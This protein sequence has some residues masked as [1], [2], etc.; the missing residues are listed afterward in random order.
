MNRKELKAVDYLHAVKGI[1]QRD[2]LAEKTAAFLS[3]SL[4]NF[5]V[6]KH[7]LKPEPFSVVTDFEFLEKN[8][9]WQK[10]FITFSQPLQTAEAVLFKEKYYIF[11]TH[12]YSRQEGFF[13]I[14]DHRPRV[15]IIDVIKSWQ[16]LDEYLKE[17]LAALVPALEGK[18]ANMVSQ[19][20]HDTEA[21]MQLIPKESMPSDL[22][23]R[24]VYQKKLNANLL[25][26][27]REPELLIEKEQVDELLYAALQFAGLDADTLP[28]TI[29]AE[30]AEIE[31][32]AELFAK[33]LSEI[34]NNALYACKG[35]SQKI[36]I[37]VD[38]LPRKSPLIDFR[39]MRIEIHNQGAIIPRDFLPQ[40]KEPF[41]TT[42]KQDGFSGFGLS[43]A[44]KIF[45]AHHGSMEISS[46]Q[47][48]GVTVTIYL[49][50]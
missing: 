17:T 42:R 43:I 28:L 24:L 27:L 47:E 31:V 30:A 16:V 3:P 5:C 15:D 34:I 22:Q 2:S 39:W 36:K 48:S 6:I 44:D 13:L 14:C 37:N 8:R 4:K 20:L 21:I 26:Y 25:F 7:R 46:S 38:V 18:N 12:D 10:D 1:F 45:R 19:L 29:S 32:D 11:L 41:F 35:D 49:P 50:M 40:V 9:E 33:A 23:Q